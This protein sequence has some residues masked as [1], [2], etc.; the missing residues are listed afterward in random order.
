[1]GSAFP[2]DILVTASV[3]RDML[4]VKDIATLL[5]MLTTTFMIV[6]EH[7]PQSIGLVMESALRDMLIAMDIAMI[8]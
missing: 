1:M 7:A 6:M 3:L 8:K 2:V 4:I 5:R